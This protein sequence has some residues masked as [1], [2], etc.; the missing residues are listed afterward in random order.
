[1][2][3]STLISPR[4]LWAA[5]AAFAFGVV[6][7]ALL[8]QHAFDMKPCPW[9]TM[10][11]LAYLAI[12]AVALALLALDALHAA[13]ERILALAGGALVALLANLGLAMALYQ[14]FVAA[15]NPSCALTFA[16]RFMSKSGLEGAL[17]WLFAASANC[18]EANLPWLGVPFALWSAAAFVLLE[19]LAVAAMI[20]A[21]RGSRR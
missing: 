14:Q 20:S 2:Q 8:L 16:D 21:L 15:Q 4:R 6:G 3:T 18:A 5:S 9:C 11:R 10:Q 17:P 13:R 7:L 12:G 19:A 1:M